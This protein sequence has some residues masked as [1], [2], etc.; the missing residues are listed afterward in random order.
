[1]LGKV[2]TLTEEIAQSQNDHQDELDQARVKKVVL[3]PNFQGLCQN[4]LLDPTVSRV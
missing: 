2:T 3:A 4:S 1:M